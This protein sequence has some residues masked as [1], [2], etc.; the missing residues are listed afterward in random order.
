MRWVAGLPI[1]IAPAWFTPLATWVER[2]RTLEQRYPIRVHPLACGLVG[3][4]SI[5]IARD[6]IG[7]LFARILV[8]LFAFLLRDIA[9]V[10]LLADILLAVAIVVGVR[11]AI[12]YWEAARPFAPVGES[13]VYRSTG[14]TWTPEKV[15][16]LEIAATLVL[17]LV[18]ASY[19][20]GLTQRY[21]HAFFG[22]AL[23]TVFRQRGNDAGGYVGFVITV[24]VV[25]LC[26]R[27]SGPAL[28]AVVQEQR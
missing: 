14:S 6:L 1:P 27:L 3:L 5:Y 13:P 23:F 16:R 10:Y 15:R 22:T 28:E 9:G 8:G 25:I 4:V 2:H 11:A 19:V 12:A 26:V 21:I 18:V 24:I 20:F 7:V 17:A